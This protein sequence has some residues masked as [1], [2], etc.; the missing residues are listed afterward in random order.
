MFETIRMVG[1]S[2]VDGYVVIDIVDV[3]LYVGYEYV[4]LVDVVYTA[5][6]V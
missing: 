4:E 6:A 3:L 5:I 1:I 2:T